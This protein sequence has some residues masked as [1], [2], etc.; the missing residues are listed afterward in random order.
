MSDNNPYRERKFF[1]VSKII[2]LGV[3]IAI[4]FPI[5]NSML[6]LKIYVP[7]FVMTIVW[8]LLLRILALFAKKSRLNPYHDVDEAVIARTKKELNASREKQKQEMS[9]L[10]L[11]MLKEGR[12]LPVLDS[13]RINNELC[14]L[15]PF[16]GNIVHCVL[17]PALKELHFCVSLGTLDPVT[18]EDMPRYRVK[19][20]QRIGEFLKLAAQNQD[21]LVL[22]DYFTTLILQCDAL[23]EDEKG[24]DVPFPVFSL[25]MGADRWWKLGERELS[26]MAELERIGD[27]RFADAKEIVPHREMKYWETHGGK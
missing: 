15:H 19:F 21:A 20:K 24:Y 1:S 17:D 2:W 7:L 3:A 9:D 8:I 13:W 27:V 23:R 12:R 14:R 25:E 11:A 10:E 18:K 6:A 16:F 22:K 26:G 5:F 4:Y